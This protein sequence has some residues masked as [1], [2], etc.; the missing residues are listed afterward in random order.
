MQSALKTVLWPALVIA[1]V[2]LVAIYFGSLVGCVATAT[3][4]EF[5]RNF[6]L[7]MVTQVRDRLSITISI[8][9][10]IMISMVKRV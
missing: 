5:R 7:S 10:N 9:I 1:A 4:A 6:W 3:S 2:R 8:T